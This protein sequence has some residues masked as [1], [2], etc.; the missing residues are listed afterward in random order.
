VW[1]QTNLYQNYPNLTNIFFRAF[2]WFADSGAT[3][4]MT[5]QLSIMRKFLSVDDDNWL[6]TGIGNSKLAVKGKGEVEITSLVNGVNLN[7]NNQYVVIHKR[8]LAYPFF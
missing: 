5:D 4:H 7:G 3:Q 2:D 1:T 8:D 6:V